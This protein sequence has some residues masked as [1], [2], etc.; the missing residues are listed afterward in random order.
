MALVLTTAQG[1]PNC[2]HSS[3]HRTHKIHDGFTSYY[4]RK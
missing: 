1:S 2:I 4:F 3:W